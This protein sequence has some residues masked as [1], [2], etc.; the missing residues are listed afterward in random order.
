MT[1]GFSTR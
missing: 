1:N